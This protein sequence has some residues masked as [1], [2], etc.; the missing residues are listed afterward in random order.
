MF[1]KLLIVTVTLTVAACSSTTN[2]TASDKLQVNLPTL[3]CTFPDSPQQTAPN[4]VCDAPVDGLAVQAMGMNDNGAAGIGHQRKLAMVDAQTLLAAQLKN[5]TELA[6][7]S[8]SATKGQAG[9]M[10]IAKK[11][12]IT[13]SL[14]VDRVLSGVRVYQSIMSKGKVYYTLVGMDEATLKANIKKV[15]KQSIKTNDTLWQPLI[16]APKAQSASK[17][18]ASQEQLAAAISNYVG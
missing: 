7:E 3:Q 13:Q 9:Q 5:K 1:K 17:Q 8:Y 4:W 11:S 10:M 15:V 6:I 14:H 16:V 12:S 18:A 2:K